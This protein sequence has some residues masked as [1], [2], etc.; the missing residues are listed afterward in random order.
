VCWF[1]FTNGQ[2]LF[3]ERFTHT[4]PTQIL[5]LLC[6]FAVTILSAYIMYYWIERPAKIWSSSLKYILKD[7]VKITN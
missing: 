4:L 3:P 5:V 6:A 7:D 1:H 2:E